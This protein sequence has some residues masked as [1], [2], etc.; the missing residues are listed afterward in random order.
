MPKLDKVQFKRSD[1]AN[2]KPMAEQLEYGEI[3]IN[4]EKDSEAIFFKNSENNITEIND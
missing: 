2:K 1:V 4:Y 3:A